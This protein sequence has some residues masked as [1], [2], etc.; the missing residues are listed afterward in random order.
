MKRSYIILFAL[1]SVLSFN[2]QKETSADGFGDTPG[3][4]SKDPITATVQGN[5]IDEN[6]AAASGVSIK[7]GNTMVQTDSKG[8]FRIINASLDKI[9]SLVTADKSGY[10]K[11]YRTFQATDAA[12]HIR[13][14][15]VKR[16]LAGTI[17]AS[18]G[19]VTLANGSKVSLPAGAVIKA[20]GGTYAGDVRV[21]AAYIDPTA[22]DIGDA[23]PGSF[24]ADNAGGDRVI[25]ASYGMMAVE[26]ESVASEKLQIAEGKEAVL[27][28][29]IPASLQT[30][31]PAS[32]SLW[33]VN[34]ETGVW[35]EEG[36]ADRSGNTYTGRVKHFSFWNCDIGLPTVTLT[37]SLKNEKGLPLVHTA[38]RLKGTAN[39][40]L[41]QGHGFTDS[42][43]SVSGLVL[44]GQLLTL[45]VL[46]DQCNSVAYTTTVGPFKTNT[47]IG[48]ITIPS[49]A[50]SVLTIRGKVLNCSGVTIANGTAMISVENASY[51]VSTD[52]QGEFSMA[53]IKCG[54]NA[55]AVSIIGIDNGAM[56]QGTAVSFNTGTSLELNAGNVVACGVSATQFV[57]YT[58]DGVS[59][60][61]NNF[62]A[63]DSFTHYVFPMQQPATEVGHS[64]G[65]SNLATGRLLWLSFISP[66]AAAGTYPLGRLSVNQY[67]NTSVISP[68]TV[69]V[70]K[71]PQV[72]GQYI[73]GTF[74]GSFRDSVGQD[75]VHRI[76]GS[77]RLRRQ[78]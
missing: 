43:G 46:N 48:T 7:V 78:Q 13:I 62:N 67:G 22:N 54:N 6:G 30:S 17:G 24:M 2:C 71:Y 15:L 31:A 25:L 37:L 19:E 77:F 42:L 16:K 20:A 73:E 18:G 51:Y 64:M 49:V 9:A 11:S 61:L 29:P 68:A 1:L 53:Y 21:Y 59:Y 76:N 50:A 38:V 28:M 12:N 8:Y 47:D 45:E 58:I 26:L 52:Q 75:P 27:T 40:A 66:G 5:V 39:G 44:A 33:Y 35:K 34:E 4:D 10:F 63:A 65:A 74:T 14:K 55:Q 72:I 70:T 60:Q 3:V 56:Q 41:T 23:V 32:I 57:N 36:K 69:S